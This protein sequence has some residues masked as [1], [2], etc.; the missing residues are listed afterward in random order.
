M[1]RT[2]QQILFLLTALAIGVCLPYLIDMAGHALDSHPATAGLVSV[3]EL[4]ASQRLEFACAAVQL[5]NNKLN[6]LD[7]GLP[8]FLGDLKQFQKVRPELQDVHRL[9]CGR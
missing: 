7:S 3:N 8:S 9:V 1:S 5:M 6:R 4:S 2:K